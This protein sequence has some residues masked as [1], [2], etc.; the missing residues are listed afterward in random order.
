MNGWVTQYLRLGSL[1]I[2]YETGNYCYAAKPF[3]DLCKII[4][5]VFSFTFT[6]RGRYDVERQV[7]VLIKNLAIFFLFP[8]ESPDIIQISAAGN[9]SP[10]TEGTKTKATRCCY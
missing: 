9:F 5:L 10:K 6:H 4:H 7:K 1:A 2:K 8:S 3:Y